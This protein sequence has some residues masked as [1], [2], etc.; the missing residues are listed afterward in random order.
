MARWMT[1]GL[2]VLIAIV[3]LTGCASTAEDQAR[4]EAERREAE[5][6]DLRESK[7]DQLDR[8]DQSLDDD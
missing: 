3:S 4:A 7:Q 5:R 2:L 8:L 1:T 6:Q